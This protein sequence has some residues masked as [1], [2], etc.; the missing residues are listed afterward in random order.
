MK[1]LKYSFKNSKKKTH[2]K[3][4][5]YSLWSAKRSLETNK[6][7][8]SEKIMAQG[9]IIQKQTANLLMLFT[10]KKSLKWMCQILKAKHN[11]G[12]YGN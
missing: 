11:V 3:D 7:T 9:K 6:K 4:Y 12:T 8:S 2:N 10:F 5:I 1:N